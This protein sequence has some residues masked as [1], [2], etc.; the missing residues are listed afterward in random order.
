MQKLMN[1]FEKDAGGSRDAKDLHLDGARR[2]KMLTKSNICDHIEWWNILVGSNGILLCI[3]C[4]ILYNPI[5]R[6]CSIETLVYLVRPSFRQGI[7]MR[8]HWLSWEEM[9]DPWVGI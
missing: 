5:M 9:P 4:I 1:L 3:F 8:P 7:L 2:R 6:Y